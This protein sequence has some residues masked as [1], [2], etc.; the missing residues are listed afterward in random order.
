MAFGEVGVDFC[1][2]TDFE[3][4]NNFLDFKFR[5][6]VSAFKNGTP[7]KRDTQKAATDP[8]SLCSPRHESVK[9]MVSLVKSNMLLLVKAILLVSNFDVS[10]K[11][12][13]SL[14]PPARPA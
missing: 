12:C 6:S 7:V 4:D 14:Q 5:C 10:P 3:K 13:Y 8:L 2:T 11:F 9:K 1:I